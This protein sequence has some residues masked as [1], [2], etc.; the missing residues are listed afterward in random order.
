MPCPDPFRREAL[1]AL[2]ER[3]KATLREVA[4][5]IGRT[6]RQAHKVLCRLVTEGLAGR[7]REGRRAVY[8]VEPAFDR[9]GACAPA[10]G[11][12]HVIPAVAAV[13]RR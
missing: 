4:V 7:R 9:V 6:D 8:R 12:R 3:G 13:P 2:R 10:A 11:N 5:G 1:E